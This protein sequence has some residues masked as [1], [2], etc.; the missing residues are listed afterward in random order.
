MVSAILHL[1]EQDGTILPPRP[2]TIIG[3]CTSHVGGGCI[4]VQTAEGDDV[5]CTP[6]ELEAEVSA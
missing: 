3:P 5:Y 1:L 4:H 2:V 6:G